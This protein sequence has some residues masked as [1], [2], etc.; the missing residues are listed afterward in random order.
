MT[1]KKTGLAVFTIALLGSGAYSLYNGFVNTTPTKFTFKTQL[2]DKKGLETTQFTI[3]ELVEYQ[4][5]RGTTESFELTVAKYKN[6]VGK[7]HHAIVFPNSKDTKIPV[8]DLDNLRSRSWQQT[9]QAIAKHVD[10]NSLFLTWWDNA[11]RLDLITGSNTWVSAPIADIY[12]D[13]DTKAIWSAISGGF[14]TNTTKLNQLANWLLMDAASAINDIK[15]T[16]ASDQKTYF[17]VSIDDLA[18]LQEISA[19]SNKKPAIDSRVFYTGNNIH[20]QISGVKQWAKADGTGS[21]LIQPLP[22]IGVRAWR[23]LDKA[24]ENLLLIKLLPFTHSLE[25]PLETVKLVFQSEWGGYLSVFQLDG[26]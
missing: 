15:K 7:S 25:Q 6:A 13:E 9:T 2:I 16:I 19:I 11:Q 1:L 8:L 22:G 4:I 23:I 24:S 20:T 17:L 5:N 18:R 3:D 12:P 26:S 10:P 21:Y 14:D